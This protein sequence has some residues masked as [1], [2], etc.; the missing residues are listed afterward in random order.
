MWATSEQNILPDKA[1]GLPARLPGSSSVRSCSNNARGS[2]KTFMASSKADAVLS[3]DWFALSPGP[4][5]TESSKHKYNTKFVTTA[6][7]LGG[8]G[9]AR[10]RA[11]GVYNHAFSAARVLIPLD[12]RHRLHA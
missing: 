1:E 5:R 7:A 9:N 2:S 11:A 12:K 4:T 10:P 8:F 6:N 3:A